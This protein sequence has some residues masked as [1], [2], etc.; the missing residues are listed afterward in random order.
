MRI[1]N[2][3]LNTDLPHLY[4][5]GIEGGLPAIEAIMAEGEGKTFKNTEAK[6]YLLKVTIEGISKQWMSKK[7][8]HRI[9]LLKYFFHLKKLMPNLK[10]DC[11]LAEIEGQDAEPIFSELNDQVYTD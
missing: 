7:E 2:L 6:I 1:N 11:H 10:I 4:A 5:M 3:P 8:K 9:S